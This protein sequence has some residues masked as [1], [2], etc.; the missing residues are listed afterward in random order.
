MRTPVHVTKN[1]L[2][3]YVL[4]VF[5]IV[6]IDTLQIALSSYYLNNITSEIG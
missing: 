5:K 1:M 2:D 6:Q 4:E 3:V